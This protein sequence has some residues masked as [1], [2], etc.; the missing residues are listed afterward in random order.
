[1]SVEVWHLKKKLIIIIIIII[2]IKRTK[3]A[4]DLSHT[5]DKMTV[6]ITLT[7]VLLSLRCIRSSEVKFCPWFTQQNPLS[8]LLHRNE[9]KGQWKCNVSIS[10]RWSLAAN[11]PP[12]NLCFCW[13]RSKH[14]LYFVDLY[15]E[16]HRY[17]FKTSL[18]T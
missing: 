12:H 3:K 6:E 11:I 1:M 8:K 2:I 13:S 4:Q 16:I 18:D 10:F 7:E 17:Y 15:P 5:C 14:P 9:W